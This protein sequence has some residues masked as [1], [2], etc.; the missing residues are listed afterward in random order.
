MQTR[1]DLPNVEPFFCPAQ[2]ISSIESFRFVRAGL[3]LLAAALD[4]TD[5][6]GVVRAQTFPVRAALK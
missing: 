2:K 4:F 1:T 6:L 3:A 5:G